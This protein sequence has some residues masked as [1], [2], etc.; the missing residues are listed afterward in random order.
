MNDN[1]SKVII[2]MSKKS[3]NNLLF[4]YSRN[5]G[6]AIP[7]ILV[8]IIGVSVAVTGLISSSVN[9]L[10][11]SKLS[12]L[13]LQ[14]KNST[15]SGVNNIRSIFNNTKGAYYYFWLAKSCSQNTKNS[16]CPQFGSASSVLWPGPFIKGQL[17]DLSRI[18]WSDSGNSWCDGLSSTQCPGRQV[19]PTCTYLGKTKSSPINWNYFRSSLS[20]LLSGND[21]AFSNQL[22]GSKRDH[23]QSYS[24]KSIDFV[25][26]ENGGENSILIEGNTKLSSNSKITSSTNKLRANI[27]VSKIVSESGFGYISAGEN[28]RDSNSLFLGNLIVS[29]NKKGSI[30]WRKNLFRTADCSRTKNLVGIKNSNQLPDNTRGEGGLWVQPLLLPP[31]PS[32]KAKLSPWSLEQVVCTQDSSWKSWTNC[33]H[34]ETT[35][36]NGYEST[37]RTVIVDD[38][39]V[40]GKDSFFGIVTSDTSRVTLVVNGSIDLSNGGR[41]CHRHKNPA[42]SC[43]SGKPHNLTILFQQPGNNALPAIANKNGKQELKC[44][45]NGGIDLVQNQNIPYNTFILSNSGHSIKQEPFSAFIY[46]TDTTLSTSHSTVKYYQVPKAGSPQLVRSRGLFAYIN[47]PESRSNKDRAPRLLKTLNNKPIPFNK[48]PKPFG[49]STHHLIAIGKRSSSSNPGENTMLNMALITDSTQN[50]YWLV[51]LNVKQYEAQFVSRN[52]NGRTWIKYLGRTPFGTTRNGRTWISHYGIDLKES[53]PNDLYITG[54]AWMKNICLDKYGSGRV[55]W[56]FKKD[57][58]QDLVKRYANN[59]R[60]NYGVPYYRGKSIKLWDTLRDFN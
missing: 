7:Q 32:R 15:T 56:D 29:G 11:S 9:R 1:N 19:G 20:G 10:S 57:F 45:A 54:A 25:G 27:Q 18:Y 3:K 59:Q 16:E 43:G 52:I 38:L 55:F 13:E 34:M 40:S 51:G 44:S 58:S 12:S 24:L 4:D 39:I 50:N 49:S 42:A 36:W 60:Y 31:P 46:A 26:S 17:P 23:F 6:F 2:L 41:I 22:P 8:L 48:A 30:I 14:A 33:R 28:Q 35:G 5:E 21:Q 47:N 37:D 53:K